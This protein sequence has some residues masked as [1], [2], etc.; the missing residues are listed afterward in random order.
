MWYQKNVTLSTCLLFFIVSGCA[1][2]TN[3]HGFEMKNYYKVLAETDPLKIG[4][5]EEASEREKEAIDRFTDFYAVFSSDRVKEGVKGLYA[6]EA[7]F[8][9]AYKA[10][11]GSDAIEDYFM[12]SAETIHECT[13]DIQDIA[14]HQGNYYFRWIMHLTTRRWK[15]EPI[16]TVGMSH[17]RFNDEGKVIFHQDYWDSSII[18][19]KVPVMGSVIRW[20]KKQF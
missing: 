9:D 16:E 18:Y 3:Q 5:L 13:F 1:T 15:N 17:V 6:E 19:E 14:V 20:I 10:V 4:A 7:Y 2:G 8:R 11:Q 12:K